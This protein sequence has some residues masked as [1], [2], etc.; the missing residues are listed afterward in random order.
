MNSSIESA[1][2]LLAEKIN[3]DIKSEDALRYTQAALNLA[4]VAQVQV[5]TA[6]SAK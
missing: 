3:G 1:I 2:K 6:K 5:Q 4:H